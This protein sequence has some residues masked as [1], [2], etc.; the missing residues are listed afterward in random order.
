[1]NK[2]NDTRY[3][4]LYRFGN[5]GFCSPV[6]QEFF[7][8]T[9]ILL[10]I[11]RIRMKDTKIVSGLRIF[12]A[13]HLG[14]IDRDRSFFNSISQSF[15]E[16]FYLHLAEQGYED[17][18]VLD[19]YSDFNTDK[20]LVKEKLKYSYTLTFESLAVL[21][22]FYMKRGLPGLAYICI[23]EALRRKPR[24]E[25]A[26]GLYKQ[27]E[28]IRKLTR[29]WTDRISFMKGDKETRLRLKISDIPM[30]QASGQIIGASYTEQLIKGFG[31]KKEEQE[32]ILSLFEEF[33]A[34]IS[35][36]KHRLPEITIGRIF[37]ACRLSHYI[38]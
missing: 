37:N 9:N 36:M 21:G 32:E 29:D 34:M 8:M 25:R 28:R 3:Y 6:G 7:L 19:L 4:L 33:H 12:D 10:F 22:G 11:A 15:I 26:E 31:K 17:M 14:I 35:E 2:W 1:M 13:K 30:L 18:Y 5:T 38:N 20:Q 27:K 23:Q 16:G 24:M